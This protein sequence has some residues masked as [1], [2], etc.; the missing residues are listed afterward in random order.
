M[1]Q[2]V[3]T[4]ALS[5]DSTKFTETTIG[6]D[7][8]DR[9]VAHLC[10]F[11]KGGDRVSQNHILCIKAMLDCDFAHATQTLPRDA[12]GA[13]CLALFA[14]R[15]LGCAQ[16]AAHALIPTPGSTALFLSLSS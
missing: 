12:P 7:L 1:Q 11:C 3:T 4:A 15:G 14:P 8:G 16:I 9:R 5:S 10:G 2:T 13:R 6:I